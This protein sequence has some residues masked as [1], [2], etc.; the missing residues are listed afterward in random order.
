MIDVG[1]LLSVFFCGA[2]IVF[3]LPAFGLE[4]STWQ[5]LELMVGVGSTAAVLYV[6]SVELSGNNA[7]QKR[8]VPLLTEEDRELAR[9]RALNNE[10]GKTLVSRVAEEL[11]KIKKEKEQLDPEELAKRKDLQEKARKTT[12]KW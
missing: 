5:S 12:R 10:N 8:L 7:N 11:E 9:E 1:K 6:V 4:I 2:A 3:W